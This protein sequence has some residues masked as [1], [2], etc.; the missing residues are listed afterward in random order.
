MRL[1]EELEISGTKLRE[2]NGR[3]LG[4]IQLQAKT[5][6]EAIRKADEIANTIVFSFA[7][8]NNLG[9][10][11]DDVEIKSKISSD[12]ISPSFGIYATEH[13]TWSFTDNVGRESL[14][15]LEKYVKSLN[16]VDPAKRD[17]PYRALHWFSRALFDEDPIDQFIGYYVA[18]E[19]LAAIYFP[20]QSQTKRVQ[21][22]IDRFGLS[23]LDGQML[24]G[25]RGALLHAGRRTEAVRQ[26]VGRV[27]EIV[28]KVF[29]SLLNIPD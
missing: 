4:L 17:Q 6:A 19:I 8:R 22:L 24:T 11:V 1:T 25:T 2:E 13:A 20:S 14:V 5:D 18:L 15:G 29:H 7:L 26:Q 28:R 27:N 9:L 10:S 3:I 21:S 16:R 23:D 12:G